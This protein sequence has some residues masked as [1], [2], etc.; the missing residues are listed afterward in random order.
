MVL[1]LVSC[2]P[3]GEYQE[4][5]RKISRQEK[6]SRLI[7]LAVIVVLMVVHLFLIQSER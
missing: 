2:L 1:T 3:N 7:W 6:R 4:Q 5:P